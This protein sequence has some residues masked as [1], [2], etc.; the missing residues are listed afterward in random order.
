MASSAKAAPWRRQETRAVRPFRSADDYLTGTAL[1]LYADDPF[2]PDEAVLA[3]SVDVSRLALAVRIPKV[4][5]DFEEVVGIASKALRLTVTIEDMLFKN[6]IVLHSVPLLEAS[7]GQ[8]DMEVEH[9]QVSHLSWAGEMRVHVAVILASARDGEAGTAW[10]VGSWVARKTFVIGKPRDITS[11][12]IDSVEPDFFEKRGLPPGATYLVDVDQDLNQGCEN[13]PEL[14]RVYLAKDV[15]VALAR[16]EGSTAAL[17]ILRE[18]Y[19]DVV[20]T[21]LGTGYRRL[22]G[23]AVAPGSILDVVTAR[24]SKSTGLSPKR[25]RELASHPSGAE[26]RAVAQADAELSRAWLSAAQRRSV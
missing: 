21:V 16:A 24:L 19:V 4:P 26:I 1:R 22:R 13:V 12:K 10:R 8:V 20:G 3:E 25:I 15:F 18:I 9:D 6:S 2:K 14:I 23:E 11:F 17:A 5:S 7:N